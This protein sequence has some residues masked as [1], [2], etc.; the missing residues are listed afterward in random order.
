MSPEERALS[1]D[2]VAKML[3]RVKREIAMSAVS[4]AAR[5][6]DRRRRMP[7]ARDQA[8]EAADDDRFADLDAFARE[9]F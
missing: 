1:R 2:R 9:T 8:R 3:E 5:G 6:V 4:A 7:V